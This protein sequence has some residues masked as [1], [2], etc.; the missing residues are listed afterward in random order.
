[1]DQTRLRAHLLDPTE[2]VREQCERCSDSVHLM[3]INTGFL[4]DTIITKSLALTRLQ[5]IVY[6]LRIRHTPW[7]IAF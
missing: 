5:E 3:P 6:F 1:V 4:L 7:R 2:F